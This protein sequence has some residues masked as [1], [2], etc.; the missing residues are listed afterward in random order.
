MGMLG[1][2]A[3]SLDVLDSSE[4]SLELDGLYDILRNQRRRLVLYYLTHTHD[5][6][7]K[8]GELA[9]QLAAWENQIPLNAVTSTQ[10]KRTY[11]TLQQHHLPKMDER[12]LVEFDRARGRIR[13]TANERQL[14][15]LLGIIPRMNPTRITGFLVIGALFWFVLS[16]NWF[17]VHVLNVFPRGFASP[18]L[19]VSFVVLLLAHIYLLYR[20]INPKANG[21]SD[22]PFNIL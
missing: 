14:R 13:L 19:G 16:M 6:S 20:F 9:E 8:I 21:S 1:T 2:T 18:L 4:D 3:V 17:A 10:R 22:T 7:A 12:G 11:N 15:V 5:E